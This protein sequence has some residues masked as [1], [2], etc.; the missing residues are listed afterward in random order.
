MN[1]TEYVEEVNKIP[2]FSDEV[3]NLR[4]RLENH[5]SNEEFPKLLSLGTGCS[6]PNKV[7][8][9]SGM[10]LQI[11][12]DISII[13]DCGEG[14]L[15]Q[16]YRLFGDFEIENVLKTIKVKIFF[17]TKKSLLYSTHTD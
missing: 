7:R 5:C 8:N 2:K 12:K 1:Q 11:N 9:V 13:L 17:S 10:L 15:G 14:T 3:V 6:I 16:L 4:K